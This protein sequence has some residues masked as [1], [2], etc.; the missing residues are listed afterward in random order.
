[1]QLGGSEMQKNV[2]NFEDS[3]TN[4]SRLRSDYYSTITAVKAIC[5]T[6]IREGDPPEHT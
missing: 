3:K 4:W 2:F 5:G 6:V 1:M